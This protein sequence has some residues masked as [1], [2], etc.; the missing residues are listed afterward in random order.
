MKIEKMNHNLYREGLAPLILMTMR[1][2][3]SL[4]VATITV[5]PEY[6]TTVNVFSI[7]LYYFG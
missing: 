6:F 1:K 5:M 7:T 3:L 4:A 2:T